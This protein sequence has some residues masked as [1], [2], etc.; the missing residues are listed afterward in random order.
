MNNDEAAENGVRAVV[1][2]GVCVRS[3]NMSRMC[4]I[5][6]NFVNGEND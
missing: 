2:V 3:E 1:R 4:G 5:L 6:C